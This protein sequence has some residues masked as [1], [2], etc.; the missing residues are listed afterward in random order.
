MKIGKPARTALQIHKAHLSKLPNVVGVGVGKKVV[1]GKQTKEDA[2]IV[3]VKKKKPLEQ[4]KT[5]E[6]VPRMVG[7]TPTD[8]IETG[9]I[10]AW[11]DPTFKYRPAFGGISIGHYRVTA[12]TLGSA[13]IDRSTRRIGILSNNHVLANSNDASAGDPILQ[14]G[15]ADG[16][17]S[18]DSLAE[19]ERFVP[20][21]MT[22]IPCPIVSA[23]CMVVNG[24]LG[25]F[26]RS[27]RIVPETASPLALNT[28]DC[29]L[30]IPFSEQDLLNEILV[31]GKP[32]VPVVGEVGMEVQK[33]GRTT[34]YTK[35]AIIAIEATTQVNYGVGMASF[36][37]QIVAGPMSAGG[38]SGSLVLDMEGNPVGLLF[39][40]SDRV[41][42]INEIQRVMDAL[43][44]EFIE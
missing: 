7:T 44:V 29:A 37:H 11:Q 42:I 2:V 18:D 21:A 9:E 30:A 10:V 19:L 32:K 13:V 14:P 16:G 12:G 1:G 40:G 15:V 28:V 5:N 8:V 39:A 27:T 24:L 3:F 6:V 20:I 17:G 22:S 33:F 41:T 34:H 31:I 4:L 36:E 25:L 23:F 43:D 38:D 35:D 26:G